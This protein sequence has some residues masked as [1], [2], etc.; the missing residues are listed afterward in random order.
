MTGYDEPLDNHTTHH[1]H[2]SGH[3]VTIQQ[4]PPHVRARSG[5]GAMSAAARR[6]SG[7]MSLSQTASLLLANARMARLDEEADDSEG[8]SGSSAHGGSRR[9]SALTGRR[10][11][12]VDSSDLRTCAMVQSRMRML[13]SLHGFVLILSM[14]R[15][16]CFTVLFML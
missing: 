15:F 6:R 2:S 1:H 10:R 11:R 7:S 12:A 5:G 14:Y 13:H 4:P 8:E 9:G 16:Y 3:H